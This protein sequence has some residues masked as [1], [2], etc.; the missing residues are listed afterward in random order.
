[1]LFENTQNA[2]QIKSDSEL[3]RSYWLF[4]LIAN[5]R[6][7]R[8]GRK[9]IQLALQLK[10]PISPLFKYTVFKQFCA[11]EH[12]N[13]SL[14]VIDRLADFN[15]YSY[16][17][18]A[19]EGE[20]EEEEFDFSLNKTLES[21][22]FST[23]HKSLPFVVFKPTGYGRLA[24]FEKVSAKKSLTEKEIQEWERIKERFELSAKK[25]V[26]TNIR[27]LIDA[28]ESWVQPA[29]DSLVESLMQRYNKDK[30][31]IHTTLQLYRTDRLEYLKKLLADAA[32]KGYK[33]G[34]KLV[35]GA[36][37]EKEK[38]RAFALGYSSPIC[39]S[40]E[41]TD[42]NFDAALICCLKEIDRMSL[43]IGS[44]NEESF[45]KA[46]KIVTE[47]NI[48]KLHPNLWFSQLYGMS[49]HITFNLANEGYQTVKYIP[50]G[51]IKEVIPYLIRRAEENT[52][53]AGQTG[54]ELELIIKEQNRRKLAGVKS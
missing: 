35:R 15:I 36:Y 34:V 1:M 44:H 9:A 27:L 32:K 12:Q 38:E 39:S 3:S 52:S 45:Y 29:I 41:A 5:E 51:P 28:E 18:Y 49:D 50:Y 46:L 11:G 47:E 54:R 7:V 42:I 8:F 21:F 4:R 2:Y 17:H 24:L 30:P 13:N 10:L 23:T 31:L 37:I 16:L 40:K 22:N 48:P 26:E 33:I 53:V 25:A 43:F 6:L 19:V 14:A 20:E